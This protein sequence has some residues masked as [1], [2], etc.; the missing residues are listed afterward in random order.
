[1]Y[2]ERAGERIW[3]GEHLQQ[4]IADGRTLDQLS[5]QAGDQIVVPARGQGFSARMVGIT[6][7]VISAAALLV[8][9]FR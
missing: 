7:G 5:L 6:T 3:T 9:I 2:I 8:T 1:M 4:A